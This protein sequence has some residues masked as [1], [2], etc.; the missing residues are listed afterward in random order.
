MSASVAFSAAAG[1]LLIVGDARPEGSALAATRG[2][3]IRSYD[4]YGVHLASDYDFCNP[5]PASPARA[6]DAE[7]VFSCVSG[8]PPWADW[9]VAEVVDEQG[10]RKDGS[11]DFVFARF[12]SHDAIRITEAVDFYVSDH[13]VIC[14]L[15]DEELRYLV[16]IALLGMVFAFWLERRGTL[17]LHASVAVVEDAAVAFLGGSGGGKTSTLVACLARGHALLVD[18]LLAVREQGGQILG[19]RGYPALRLLPEQADRFLGG[20]EDLPLLHPHF[21]K[22]RALIGPGAF[23]RFADGPAPIRR[24]YLPERLAPVD[25]EVEIERL[26]ADEAVMALMRHSFLPREMQRF[27]W[28]PRRLPGLTTIAAAAP[29]ARLRYPSGFDRLPDVL[30]HVELDLLDE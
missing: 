2:G 16:E 19:E 17:T 20:H 26:R 7:V 29:V 21:T 14:H 6:A 10:L 15:L 5:L 4:V 9:Q 27:G 30:R 11:P 18:D 23:G 25:A 1:K 22:R 12:P 3:R 28:Q 24:L 13:E 8:A